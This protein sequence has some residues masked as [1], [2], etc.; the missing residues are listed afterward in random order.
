MYADEVKYNLLK[1]VLILLLLKSPFT[2]SF[3][4]AHHSEQ[5]ELKSRQSVFFP[6]SSTR[7]LFGVF[8]LTMAHKTTSCQ[9]FFFPESSSMKSFGVFL[10]T[11]ADKTTSRQLKLGKRFKTPFIRLSF[12]FF[13]WSLSPESLFR[14]FSLTQRIKLR[15]LK[16]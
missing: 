13:P 11:M 3:F 15:Q 4:F 5:N 7:K 8:L 12:F 9:F 14:V 16:H 2:R 1:E 6:E 10:L